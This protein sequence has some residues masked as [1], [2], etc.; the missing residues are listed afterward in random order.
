MGRKRISR[1]P[2]KVVKRFRDVNHIMDDIEN[3]IQSIK[4]GDLS[5]SKARV[6]AKNRQ[7]QIDAI[8]LLLQAA[9]IEARFRPALANRL[10][11]EVPEVKA[12]ITQ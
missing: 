4:D 6:V 3:E 2:V 7:M 1:F 11:L 5:E 12:A 9:R 10:G 8:N